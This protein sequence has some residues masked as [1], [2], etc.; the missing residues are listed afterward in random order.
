MQAGILLRGSFVC[1]SAL[2][3]RQYLSSAACVIG[4][5]NLQNALSF[6][7]WSAH[8]HRQISTCDGQFPVALRSSLLKPRR[9][10][11]IRNQSTDDGEVT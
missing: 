5:Y 4:R 8:F 11:Q 7:Q 10:P 2:I 9:S 1:W 3:S 6:S